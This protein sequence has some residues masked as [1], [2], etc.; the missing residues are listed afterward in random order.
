MPI[1]NY[2]SGRRNLYFY[3]KKGSKLKLDSEALF[4]SLFNNIPIS[5]FSYF[6][7]TCVLRARYILIIE[8][9]KVKF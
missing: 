3:E 2:K 4:L 7:S 9:L 8:L 6:K 5:H 1:F